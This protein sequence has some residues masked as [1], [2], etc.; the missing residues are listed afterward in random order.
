MAF[1]LVG[2]GNPGSEYA[3]TRHNVGFSVIEA[4]AAKHGMKFQKKSK[5]K[6]ELAS[7]IID[8]VEVFLLK[9]ET[10]MNL[11]GRSL[12]VASDFFKIDLGHLLVIA[13][14]A[15]QPFG[16]LRLKAESGSGGHKG[17]ESI[18]GELHSK[19]Y[20]RLKIGVGEKKYNDMATHVL[21]K[22]SQNELECLP[23]IEKKAIEAIELFLKEGLE[24]AMN[25]ANVRKKKE[26]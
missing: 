21:G 15:T 7:G 24:K 17:L 11:S 20:A 13:D 10:Y 12:K 26:I 3:K 4:L 16:Q 23:E 2:L 25:V 9:P 14:D 6:G 19:A 5:L 18:E 22:F 1:L 8:G